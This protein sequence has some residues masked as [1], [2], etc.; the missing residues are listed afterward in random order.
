MIAQLINT[1][2][3]M[4][5]VSIVKLVYLLLALL[6][7]HDH[8]R[9][10]LHQHRLVLASS[11]FISTLPPSPFR[12][13]HHHHHHHRHSHDPHHHYAHSAT[14]TAAEAQSKVGF[15]CECP[16]TVTNGLKQASKPATINPQSQTKPDK[17][18]EI[19]EGILQGPETKTFLP[20]MPATTSGWVCRPPGGPGEGTATAGR[21]HCRDA[22]GDRRG[23]IPRL[24]RV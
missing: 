8:F 11:S 2:T 19:F 6:Q 20:F 18:K 14:S 13:C 10:H 17:A 7:A 21:L 12:H 22:P 15:P 9:M 4:T 3:T 24:F 23:L 16:H 1:S 5:I